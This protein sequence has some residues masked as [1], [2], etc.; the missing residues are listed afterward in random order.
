MTTLADGARATRVAE[1]GRAR[2]SECWQ[3]THV[4]DK[5]QQNKTERQG[6]GRACFTLLLSYL[7]KV[8]VLVVD[9]GRPADL[10]HLPQLF[11]ALPRE[12]VRVAPHPPPQLGR[13]LVRAGRQ[14]G[15]QTGRQ[16]DRQAG[17]LVF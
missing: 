8:W 13:G 6:G 10:A 14:A 16:A 11:R 17:G 9:V 3:R 4:Q 7:D 2:L 15:R 5:T 12:Q 1:T